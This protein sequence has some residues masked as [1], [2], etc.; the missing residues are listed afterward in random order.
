LAIGQ[1]SEVLPRTDGYYI[2]KRID[3]KDGQIGVKYIF[4]AAQT[5]EQYIGQ[6]LA[7]T[8]VFILAD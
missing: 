8:K 6:K 1:T 4:V 2:V 7:T 3:D 5:L